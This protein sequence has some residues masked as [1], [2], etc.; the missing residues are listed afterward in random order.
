[1]I[2]LRVFYRLGPRYYHSARLFRREIPWRDK[3][4]YLNPVDF[5][6]AVRKI[7]PPDYRKLSQYK[8]AEKSILETLTFPTAEFIGYLNSRRGCSATGNDLR[9][10]QELETCL[11]ALPTGSKICFKL[12]EGWGGAGFVAIE[13]EHADRSST[14]LRPL[15]DS[16]W[17]STKDFCAKVLQLSDQS[18]YLI[19]HYLE[20]HPWYAE[21]NSSSINTWRI[22]VLEKPGEEAQIMCAYI[23]IGR[24]GS[25]VDN[26]SAGGMCFP[27]DPETGQLLKGTLTELDEDRFERHPDTGM[28]IAGLTPPLW[29]E[30]EQ[31]ARRV[32]RIFPRM[33]FAG[34]DIAVTAAGPIIV[35]I[36]NQPD[37]IGAIVVDKPIRD[38]LGMD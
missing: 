14:R 6:K 32:L 31:L 25:L 16:D 20:Q 11:S 3:T 26:S 5:A 10:H 30:V 21:L 35:E 34:L 36:N 17:H 19:E 12:L 13:I 23:R 33:S 1:M 4:R 18:E 22:W 38:L 8:L 37:L 28:Q 29:P 7:N 27:F 9:N 24:T 15:Q 2:A